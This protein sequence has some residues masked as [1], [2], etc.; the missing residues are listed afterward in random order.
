M[1]G[2]LEGRSCIG[3]ETSMGVGTERVI[4]KFLVSHIYLPVTLGGVLGEAL[5]EVERG[6]TS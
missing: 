5:I 3:E 4:T 1:G 2:L 6:P